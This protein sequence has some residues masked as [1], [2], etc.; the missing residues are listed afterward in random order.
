MNSLAILSYIES[1]NKIVHDVLTYNV[2]ITK[3]S[4][5]E[6]DGE[7]RLSNKLSEDKI[8]RDIDLPSKVVK[9]L[10]SSRKGKK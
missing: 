2:S 3:D 10:K 1:P 5:I 4:H 9:A 7:I 8:F 6:E